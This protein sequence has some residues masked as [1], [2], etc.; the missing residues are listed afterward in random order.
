MRVRSSGSLVTTGAWW[1]TAVTMTIASMTSAVP[2]AAQATPAARPV[3]WSSG[4]MSQA[5]RTREI[6]CWGPPR[7]AWARTTTGTSGRIRALVTS[8]CRARKSGLAG[9]TQFL[10]IGVGLPTQGAV[11]EV[12]REVNPDV[13]DQIFSFFDGFELLEPGLVPKHRWRPV[14]GQAAAG[15]PN[16][17]W[18][19]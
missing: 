9:I 8:S 18:G 1:R 19:A 7:Q 5:L 2:A 17:Q 12:A 14:T 16:I 10:D 11:H 15:T 6:W 13:R 4:R 3:R